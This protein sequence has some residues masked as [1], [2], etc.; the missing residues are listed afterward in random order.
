MGYLVDEDDTR[1]RSCRC[2]IKNLDAFESDVEG[3]DMEDIIPFIAEPEDVEWTRVCYA[4]GVIGVL[5]RI[6]IND[7]CR[8]IQYTSMT[9]EMEQPFLMHEEAISRAKAEYDE[10]LEDN[11]PSAKKWN[12]LNAK[13]LR[14]VAEEMGIRREFEE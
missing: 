1:L 8:D 10:W 7:L 12:E 4:P 13:H 2:L 6:Q 14:E 11:R 5:S 9:S 3:M